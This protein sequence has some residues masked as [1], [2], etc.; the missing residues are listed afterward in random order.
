MEISS[1]RIDDIPLLAALL[2]QME[3]AKWIDL[4]LWNNLAYREKL[5]KK[6]NKS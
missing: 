3:V 1:E 5:A 4:V 6:S 2:N